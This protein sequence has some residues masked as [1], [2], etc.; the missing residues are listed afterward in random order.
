MSLIAAYRVLHHPVGLKVC[1]S[2]YRSQLSLCYDVISPEEEQ[3]VMQYLTPLLAKRRYEGS[4][5]DSVITKYKEIELHP[6]MSASPAHEQA[7][8]VFDKVRHKIRR[9][10]DDPDMQ[11]LSTHCIDLSKDGHIGRFSSSQFC[12]RFQSFVCVCTSILQ[13]A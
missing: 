11:F 4:H 7:S 5:W 8:A 9:L 10:C 3:V 12:F 2:R 13:F 6:P 1:G